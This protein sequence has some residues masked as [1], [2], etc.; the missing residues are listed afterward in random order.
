MVMTTIDDVLDYEA[1]DKDDNNIRKT[2]FSEA[3]VT[4][5]NRYASVGFCAD[6]EDLSDRFG[7]MR[8]LKRSA[9]NND[10]DGSQHIH[11]HI[12]FGYDD[13]SIKD[14]LNAHSVGYYDAFVERNTTSY[15]DGEYSGNQYEGSNMFEA[16][17]INPPK[18][19]DAVRV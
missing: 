3:C 11:E 6:V 14:V 4:L 2:R 7:T 15:D 1:F 18:Y 12:N 16:I 8:I 9:D 5:L 17:V 19:V 13:V 10:V